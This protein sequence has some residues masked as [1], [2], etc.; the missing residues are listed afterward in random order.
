MK[1]IIQI[2]CFNEED[3]LT[4]T[5][6]ALPKHIEG[7]DV[8]E[9]LVVDDGS[10][11]KTADVAS[12]NGIN[13]IIKLPRHTGL[14]GAFRTGLNECLKRG[15]DIIVNTDADNQYNADDIE[16]LVKPIIENNADMVVGARPIDDIK[17]F[18]LFKK[19]MQKLGSFVMR[20]VSSTEISDA[21]SGFRAFS[22]ECA[23]VLNVFDNYTYTMETIIQ[24][25]AKG[26]RILSVPVRVNPQ[27]R[28]SRLVKNIFCYIHKSSFTILRMF[29]VYRPFRFFAFLAGLFLLTGFILA[30]RF[31]YFYFTI[32][33]NGHIQSLILA[34]ILI[35]TGVHTG[36]IGILAD[37]CAINRK[38][39][40]DI[41]LRV[42]KL[43]NKQN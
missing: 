21:P 5:I 40:E 15:A 33:G 23:E 18:T 30:I 19:M 43:E 24:A 42:K 32:G 13:H 22:A 37:L 41:Q 31:L 26:L 12:W 16:K 6:N 2:P 35:L 17:G 11:D 27:T 8:I 3:T 39:S 1:L 29:I 4:T 9:T 34:S 14:A 20:L 7:I 36:L 25:K 10:F 38:L 28:K